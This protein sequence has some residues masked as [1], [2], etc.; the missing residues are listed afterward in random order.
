MV[1]WVLLLDVAITITTNSFHRRFL[2]VC[3]CLCL[4]VLFLYS[5]DCPLIHSTVVHFIS[6]VSLTYLTSLSASRRKHTL[7]DIQYEV[8]RLVEQGAGDQGCA[9]PVMTVHAEWFELQDV[10]RGLLTHVRD[11]GI[12]A[13]FR[14]SLQPHQ[15][16][17]SRLVTAVKPPMKHHIHPKSLHVTRR[18]HGHVT[19]TV[20][21]TVTQRRWR[22]VQNVI[23]YDSTWNAHLF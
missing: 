19:V 3:L 7:R 14:L 16:H 1:V 23:T 20:T 8:T 6:L 11:S 12:A 4:Y 17:S 22:I 9:I 5:S 15:A 18:F 2:D 21:V 13:S 10:S